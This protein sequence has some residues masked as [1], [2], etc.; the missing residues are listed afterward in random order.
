MQL[1]LVALWRLESEN[2][3]FGLHFGDFLV[4]PRYPPTCKISSFPRPFL[5][6]IVFF[7][8]HKRRFKNSCLHL[9]KIIFSISTEQNGVGRTWRD[10]I[11]NPKCMVIVIVIVIIIVDYDIEH[12]LFA[13]RDVLFDKFG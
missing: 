12:S 10:M 9:L 13:T 1:V 4:V 11:S 8:Y 2:A 7:L 3:T 6:N 5:E